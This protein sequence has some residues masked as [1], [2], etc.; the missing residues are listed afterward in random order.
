[1]AAGVVDEEVLHADEDTVRKRQKNSA[2]RDAI[3]GQI[4]R[5]RDRAFGE[6]E[7]IPCAISGDL[8]TKELSHVDHINFFSDLMNQFLDLKGHPEVEIVPGEK[9]ISPKIADL[10]LRREWQ[11]YHKEHAQL[12]VVLWRKNL[13]RGRNPS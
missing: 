5:F 9:G 3:S 1:M 8:I 7:K 6:N 4:D 13:T 11:D 2:F 10:V 12:R